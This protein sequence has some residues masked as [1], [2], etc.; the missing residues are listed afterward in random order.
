M[1]ESKTPKPP[2]KSAA[3]DWIIR[4]I[5]FGGLAV[6][7]V[8]AL[9]DFQAKRAAQDAA[10][11]WRAAIRSK[12]EDVDL[13]KSEFSKIAVPG[14]PQVTSAAAGP[15]PFGARTLET[16]T[17]KGTFRSYSVRVLVGAGM[18]PSIE[19]IQGPGEDNQD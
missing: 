9:L 10:D 16:Y 11:A 19:S 7:L 17:W 4:G 2:V 14:S 6:L 3:R 13:T 8:L 18:D 1:S 5:V 12:G 15:N